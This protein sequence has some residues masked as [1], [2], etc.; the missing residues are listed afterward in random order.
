[1]LGSSDKKRHLGHEMREREMH[2]MNATVEGELHFMIFKMICGYSFDSSLLLWIRESKESKSSS[3]PLLTFFW[4]PNSTFFPTSPSSS[5]SIES[6]WSPLFLLFNLHHPPCDL[7]GR[8]EWRQR[9]DVTQ[10]V[11]IVICLSSHVMC[12]ILIHSIHLFQVYL[13]I[14]SFFCWLSLKSS[15]WCLGV[16]GWDITSSL[17]C[18]GHHEGWWPSCLRI[19]MMIVTDWIGSFGPNV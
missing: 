9:C 12:S 14:F 17:F 4:D 13:H 1:M 19:M 15:L 10:R 16:L 2:L 8:N 3:F 11:W 5:W 18:S 6:C 7:F